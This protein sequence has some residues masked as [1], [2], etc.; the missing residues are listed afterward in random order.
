VIGIELGNKVL[1]QRR[2]EKN[3]KGREEIWPTRDVV[4]TD[5]SKLRAVTAGFPE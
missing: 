2:K 4:A 1:T 5:F 3:T